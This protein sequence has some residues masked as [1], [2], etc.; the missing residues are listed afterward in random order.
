MTLGRCG[1]YR[2]CKGCSCRHSRFRP[3]IGQIRSLR[4]DAATDYGRSQYK[5]E[6]CR[7]HVRD[8]SLIAE[9]HGDHQQE[10]FVMWPSTPVLPRGQPDLTLGIQAHSRFTP[11][12]V[13]GKLN[14][15]G[16]G[17]SA[18]RG[19]TVSRSSACI[20]SVTER[21]IRPILTSNLQLLSW[22]RTIP[23]SPSNAPA[24]TLTR[25]PTAIN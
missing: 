13:V 23:S 5:C 1:A 4:G 16:S 11:P 22:R 10:T 12:C 3:F 17:S 24:V 15:F 7:S 20:L 2:W 21:W 9:I 14:L 6:T 25:S 8:M 19:R 18:R